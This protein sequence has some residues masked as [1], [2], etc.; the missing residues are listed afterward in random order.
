MSRRLGFRWVAP[1]LL[2]ACGDA[3][4]PGA[5]ESSSS[6]SGDESSGAAT[7]VMTTVVTTTASTTSDTTEGDGS[8]SDTGTTGPGELPECH[9][10]IADAATAT[11]DRSAIGTGSDLDMTAM[12]MNAS[13]ETVIVGSHTSAATIGDVMLPGSEVATT[14]FAAKY[15]AE[16]A[17]VWARQL[18][19]PAKSI[20][21][22]AS[23]GVTIGSD[24]DLRRLDGESG[25]AIWTVDRLPF[26][27]AVQDDG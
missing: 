17:L 11:F 19:Y 13:G 3:A 26:A 25:D 18:P 21:F 6:S 4:T 8:E 2:L 23:G 7:T 12:A 14:G 1:T 16:L 24:L 22:D 27:F 10:P 5:S 15:D 9:G 20:A